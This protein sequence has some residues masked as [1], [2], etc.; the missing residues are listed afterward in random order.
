MEQLFSQLSETL[1]NSLHNDEQIK[2]SID[3]ENSQFVRFSQSKI[4]QSGLVD[5]AFL[6]I[7]LINDGRTCN[8]SFT[9]TG[10]IELDEQTAN[11]ELNRLFI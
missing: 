7:S 8:G 2:L 9:L 6:S 4:R 3:G 1:I 5:D 11:Q 10:N